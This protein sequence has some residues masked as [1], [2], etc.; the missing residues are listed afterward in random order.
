MKF[1]SPIAS[2]R[3]VPDAMR[4]PTSDVFGWAQ[5]FCSQ[6]WLYRPELVE[7]GLLDDSDCARDELSDGC[8]D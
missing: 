6:L 2:L 7:C 3:I 4:P 8:W 1:K 5:R